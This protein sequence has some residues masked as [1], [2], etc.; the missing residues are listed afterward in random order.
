MG[1]L[2]AFRHGCGLDIPGGP[3]SH[4]LQA[5]EAWKAYAKALKQFYEMKE[6]IS[7]PWK[8]IENQQAQVD[9]CREILQIMGEL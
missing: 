2:L 6:T 5:K 4:L 7:M 8:E 9:Q 1:G 3:V